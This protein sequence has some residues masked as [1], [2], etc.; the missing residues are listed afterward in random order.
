[1]YQLCIRLADVYAQLQSCQ[2][3][4]LVISPLRLAEVFLLL[5][6]NPV[7]SEEDV[8]KEIKLTNKSLYQA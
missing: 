6:G 3:L 1:M 5:P 2:L 4:L 7:G 8:C